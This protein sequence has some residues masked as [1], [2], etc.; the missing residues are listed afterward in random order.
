MRGIERHRQR[1]RQREKQA[2]LRKP[3]V[4]LD[5]PTLG[6]RPEP[7]TDAQLLSHPGVPHLTILTL[8]KLCRNCPYAHLS[9]QLDW[10]S[11]T[12]PSGL[13]LALRLNYGDAWVAQQLSVCLWLRA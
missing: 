4:G 7:K 9:F 1:H 12:E 8:S 11:Y 2:P 10:R 5:P 13:G 3:D 6:S